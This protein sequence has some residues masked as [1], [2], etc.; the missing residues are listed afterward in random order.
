MSDGQTAS[1]RAEYERLRELIERRLDDY[2]PTREKTRDTMSDE[3]S[4]DATLTDAMRYSLM[5]GGKRIRPAL[6][7]L[8]SIACDTGTP[9]S[10]VL[11]AACG[12]ECL[13]TYSLIHDDLPQMDNDDT[14][15]GK[16]SNHIIFGEWLAILAGDALQ[17]KAFGLIA[18]APLPPERVVKM[19]TE[20]ALAAG[21]RGICGGQTL[22]IY[23]EKRGTNE[24]G[25]YEIHRQKTSSLIEAA[26]KIGVHAAGGTDAQLRAA[27]EYAGA[28]GMAF[29]IRDDTLDA[30]ADSKI[31]GK[32]TFF[33]LFGQRRCEELIAEETKRA[34]AA[35]RAAFEPAKRAPLEWLA[36]ELSKRET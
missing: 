29:Q 23:A 21:E 22:D 32:T 19:L 6:T 20:L 15:R 34:K 24:A 36:D 8:F 9:T 25:L 10:A 3:T 16:P 30:V 33:T 14:R 26:A 28:V 13:H 17:A 12:I 11:D 35:L 18:A 1:S 5:A 4:S 7:L 27:E 2:F 31:P